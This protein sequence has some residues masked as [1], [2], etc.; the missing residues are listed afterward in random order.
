MFTG[1]LRGLCDCLGR[2]FG[3][4]GWVIFVVVWDCVVSGIRE[5]R[6][7]FRAGFIR[8]LMEFLK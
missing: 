8:I 4:G 6:G 7:L 2:F 1:L 5:G 3:S